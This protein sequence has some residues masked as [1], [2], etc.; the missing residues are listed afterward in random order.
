M[1]K[2]N[3]PA[4]LL[5]LYADI[6]EMM[7]RN[8]SHFEVND[9]GI[10]IF[11]NDI[12]TGFYFK[13]SANP[14]TYMVEFK[15]ASHMDLTIFKKRMG[16]YEHIVGLFKSWQEILKIYDEVPKMLGI[17]IEQTYFDEFSYN[18]KLVDE[19][20]D[21]KPFDLARQVF[22]TE[23]C[24]RTE[25]ILLKERNDN[26]AYEI[27]EIISKVD[28]LKKNIT[29][30]TKSDVFNRLYRIWAKIRKAGLQLFKDVA[31]SLITDLAKDG[32]INVYGTVKNALPIL[33]EGAKMLVEN[34]IK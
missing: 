7:D 3:T 34:T 20:A 24:Q 18:I 16:K 23:Y 5:S 30:S 26:N 32:V 33:M 8:L 11:D 10:C 9:D 4:A 6:N 28:D 15:P 14:T 13:A 29:K 19:D 27:D 2:Q 12:S 25:Q 1:K 17:D 21:T 22:L 31:V